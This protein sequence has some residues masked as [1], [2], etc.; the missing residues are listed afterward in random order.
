[1]DAQTQT[2]LSQ[3][4]EDPQEDS[5]EVRQSFQN[6]KSQKQSDYTHRLNRRPRRRLHRFIHMDTV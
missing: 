4:Y 1:M 2:S 3:Q 5:I 6:K